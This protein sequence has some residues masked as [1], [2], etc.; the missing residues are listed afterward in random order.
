MLLNAGYEAN[1]ELFNNDATVIYRGV[2][3]IDQKNVIIKT[4]KKSY[5]SSK[6]ILR[7]KREY[8]LSKYLLNIDGVRQVYELIENNNSLMLVSEDIGGK[9]L[10]KTFLQPTVTVSEID[11]EERLAIAIKI[12]NA[13]SHIHHHGI[14]HKD[15]S[16]DNIV[17]NPAT[18]QVKIIDFGISSLSSVEQHSFQNHNELEGKAEYI[19]PE[20]TGRINR[21]IDYRSDLYSLGVT[22]YQ[23]FTSELPFKEH[24]RIELIHAHIAKV[25]RSPDEI[26]DRLPLSLVKII[27]R[28]LCKSADERYQTAS[29][30]SHDL[31]LCLQQLKRKSASD[32]VLGELDK[33]PK[34]QLKQKLYGREGEIGLLL[35]SFDRVAQSAAEIILVS[36]LSG[37]GKSAL[38]NEVHKPLTEKQ[39][40]FI[41]GKFEKNR[42]S[43]PFYAWRQALTALADY[44]LKEDEASLIAW[45]NLIQ[46]AVGDNGQVIIDAIPTFELILGKQPTAS[47]LTGMQAQHR[48]SYV[49][50]QFI[51]AIALKE[52]PLVI[53][54]DD[55]QWADTASIKLLKSLV[56]G[57][58]KQYFLFIAAYRDNE[59]TT[60]HPFSLSLS[61]IEKSP[62]NVEHFHLENLTESATHEL[63][64]DA[65]QS[66]E[67]TKELSRLVYEKTLGNAFFLVQFL[68]MLEKK[69]LLSFDLQQ[70]HWVWELAELNKLSITRNVVD[71]MVDKIKQLP[72]PSQKALKYAACLGNRFHLTELANILDESV[73]Q[74]ASL[75]NIPVKEGILRYAKEVYQFV[76]DRVQQAAYSIFDEK[77]KRKVHYSI[78]KA[79]LNT[80]SEDEQSKQLFDIVRHL[81]VAK[82]IIKENQEKQILSSLNLLAGQRAKQVTAY[83]AALKHFTNAISV[84]ADDCWH[85][86]NHQSTIQLY[87]EAA[88]VAYFL[89]L[90]EQ[91]ESWL[92]L[93]L[94]KAKTPIERAQVAVIHLQAYT[95]QNRLS[96][97]VDASLHAL[98]LLEVNIPKEP[99]DLQVIFNLLKTKKTLKGH[100]P[101]ELLSL[102]QMTDPQQ[103]LIMDILGLTVPAAYWT[104]PNLVAMIIFKMTQNSVTQG[105]APISG[106]A[107]SWWGITECAML[108]NIESGYRYGELGIKLA[109][110]HNLYLQQPV[111]FSGW[112]IN[113]YKHPL[114]DSLV[115]LDRAYS[116]SLEKGDYE[117]A[118]YALNN[119]IQHKLHCG[120][121]LTTLLPSMEN[122]HQ[123]LKTFNMASSQ[124][125][126]DIC[127]QLAQNLSSLNTA[128]KLLSGSAY[129][130]AEYLAQ[131]LKEN[132]ASTLFFLYFAKLMQS[133]LLDDIEQAQVNRRKIKPYLKAGMGTYQHRLFYFYDSLTLLANENI[134]LFKKYLY[135][136]Q[137]LLN[138]RKLKKWAKFSPKNHLHQWHLVQ[139]EY[140]RVTNK[141]NQALKH[142]NL[143]T[144]LA[145]ESGFIHEEALCYELLTKFHINNHQKRYAVHDLI[146]SHYLYS[147][148]GAAGKAMQLQQHYAHTFPQ[149]LNY[150]D[151]NNQEKTLLEPDYTQ[152]SLTAS[153][154]H[155]QSNQ[156]DLETVIK[157][158]Q[159]IAGEIVFADLIKTLSSFILENAGAQRFLLLK[160]SSEGSSIEF[161]SV[162]DNDV[163][164]SK[165]PDN[166]GSEH[167]QYAFPTSLISYVQ[168]TLQSVALENAL[169]HD[170]FCQDNYF[171][172]NKVKSAFCSPMLHQGQLTGII[173]LENRLIPGVFTPE[174]IELIQLLSSQAAISIENSKLYSNL[175]NKV[176]ERTQQ[177]EVANEQLQL[178]ATT[179]NLTNLSNRR[180]F[181]DQIKL[182]LGRAKRNQQV[183]SLLLCDVDNFKTFND[184]Y[185]HIDG[186]ECLRKIGAVFQALFN[187]A[188][189]LAARYG[190]E[191]FAVILTSI[192]SDSALEMANKLCKNVQELHIPHK[193][194]G[195]HDMVTISVGCHSIVPSLEQDI[196]SQIDNLLRQTDKALYLAKEK[197][198]NCAATLLSNEM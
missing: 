30:L 22:L 73:E 45:R 7:V 160:V 83:D 101:Q 137:V 3:A 51:S 94:E 169:T 58:T 110:T 135:Q 78:A 126:H 79:L 46:D 120:E 119:N 185:G 161:E 21:V 76:H 165:L 159:L 49:F 95:A 113:N 13:L 167:A 179:D 84:L 100:S 50:N 75:I 105:Y 175:E 163:I 166:E 111:F 72:A 4:L 60:T 148:W 47:P 156:L 116:L 124:F 6:E 187:R 132:D 155:H 29:G 59:I 19:S 91:M 181:N 32:F 186:D 33:S 25:P 180:Q 39:G 158:S 43:T 40:L 112:M 139:A 68:E 11:I 127:W 183:I 150:V 31:S 107:F 18:E 182:E 168:R 10:K 12:A 154:S 104:S 147:Q 63:I 15:I 87:L 16:P 70:S 42:R 152:H 66:S 184:C 9:T 195:K 109:E 138:Q 153:T 144:Q 34:L 118:S 141:P 86:D 41:S 5:P 71:L 23:L 2:R 81:N 93:V 192:D 121:V 24:H 129:D 136:R 193:M 8:E 26:N 125:W 69:E 133:Y 62:L 20:Q 177:L 176:L 53:F 74:T 172:M 55:W 140:F 36:G 99:N 48:L 191:E 90:F 130:E 88:E 178:L 123:T 80:L 171:Q 142:Y 44:I 77:T 103:L 54:I 1:E 134:P 149:I 143:A 92:A 98:A 117:Y 151:I 65:L 146:Q 17:Y 128:P 174:R 106:Y 56:K 198:R 157:S 173:Y 96:E 67:N 37:V 102:N 108:G 122:A 194:N 162:L 115:I 164:T 61:T 170:D 131:H 38:V 85:D 189:D 196:D 14:I 28:L 188:S 190:G 114:A 64:S 97:A 27:N 145:N 197:G 57:K 35:K 52:H 82:P 89:N